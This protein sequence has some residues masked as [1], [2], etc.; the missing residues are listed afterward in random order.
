MTEG[1]IIKQGTVESIEDELDGGRIKVRLVEDKDKPL[2]ELP[3][4]FPL[5]PKIFQCVPKV[6]EGVFVICS[7]FKN[8]KSQRYYIGPIISQMQDIGDAPYNY[9]SGSANSLTQGAIVDS[10]KPIS[11]FAVTD[12][13]FPDKSDIAI[14]GRKGEDII[15]RDDEI[16]LRCGIRSEALGDEDESL[17]GNVLFNTK[18][19]TYIQMK[20]KP[21]LT[22][23]SDGVIN[24]VA[25]KINIV[26]HQDTDNDINVK[27]VNPNSKKNGKSEP[28]LHDSDLET[29]MTQLHQL[30]YGDVLVEILN[31][32]IKALTNHTHAMNGLP[33]CQGLSITQVNDIDLNTLLSKH[34]R[35]S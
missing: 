23:D 6:N 10:F 25:D 24:L 32:I 16:D 22:S 4:A 11:N 28:L 14:I 35:I 5:N 17:V 15:V 3:Y 18:N 8:S 31:K 29:L 12:G 27:L 1:Y 13:S 20:H 7:E 26:S 33:P 30:P 9:G 34:V 19:P 2:S 21:H